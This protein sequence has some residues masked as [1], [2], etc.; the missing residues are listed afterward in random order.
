[1]IFPSLLS[2]TNIQLHVL[3]LF[4]GQSS[5]SIKK[6]TVNFFPK[7]IFLDISFKDSKNLN[8]VLEK[9]PNSYYSYSSP[10]I[11]SPPNI[12]YWFLKLAVLF[13]HRGIE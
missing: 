4:F 8:F 9:R 1:M 11:G 10:F 2:S 5:S 6:N 7:K 3:R 12:Y 13:P